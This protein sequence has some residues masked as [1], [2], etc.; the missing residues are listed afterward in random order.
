[1]AHCT[2]CRDGFIVSS[3]DCCPNCLWC[4]RP[5]MMPNQRMTSPPQFQ[6]PLNDSS[7]FSSLISTSRHASPFWMCQQLSAQSKSLFH[8]LIGQKQRARHWVATVTVSAGAWIGSRGVA[9]NVGQCPFCCRLFP[10]KTEAG[11][12]LLPNDWAITEMPFLSADIR[13]LELR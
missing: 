9:A 2:Q 12:G 11:Q 5:T 3:Y 4:H 7:S 8:V 13:A 10:G 6:V 1:M